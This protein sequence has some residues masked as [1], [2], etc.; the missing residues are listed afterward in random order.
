M[1]PMGEKF[2]CYIY[3]PNREAPL[4]LEIFAMQNFSLL[5]K[6]PIIVTELLWAIQNDE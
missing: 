4:S 1:A 5:A 6:P 2:I 3:R